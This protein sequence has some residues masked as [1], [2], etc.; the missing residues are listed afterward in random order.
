MEKRKNPVIQLTN[1]SGKY[2]LSVLLII[3]AAVSL[4]NLVQVNL[5]GRVVEQ[6]HDT[7]LQ[8]EELL[9][10]A[11]TGKSPISSLNSKFHDL[12]QKVRLVS[13]CLDQLPQSSELGSLDNSQ[14]RLDSVA[15][16]WRD[17]SPKDRALML[18][19]ILPKTRRDIE[20]AL[21]DTLK[22]LL[23]FKLYLLRSALSTA[24]M[25]IVIPVSW[26]LSGSR[27][28]QLTPR[29]LA[30]MSLEHVPLPAA[31]FDSELNI[32]Y[33][34]SALARTT[35]STTSDFESKELAHLINDSVSDR[36]K[37]QI[38]AST[39]STEKLFDGNIS[40]S[41]RFGSGV[42][43]MTMHQVPITDEILVFADFVNTSAEIE[44]ANLKR[45]VLAIAG[46]E[47]RT[48]LTS[49]PA[50]ISLAL[51]DEDNKLTDSELTELS[52]ADSNL[53]VLCSLTSN[54]ME[55]AASELS[56][57]TLTL[58]AITL[59]KLVKQ[60]LDESREMIAKRNLTISSN[61]PD[62][63]LF[64]D[65]QKV[66]QALSAI[67]SYAI[68][69]AQ[70]GTVVSISA[71]ITDGASHLSILTKV[72]SM[73]FRDSQ[74]EQIKLLFPALVLQSHGGFLEVNPALEG[75]KKLF[76]MKLPSKQLPKNFD[77]E[78]SHV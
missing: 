74:E 61:L 12:H 31:A 65:K 27:L 52:T 53:Q 2:T 44:A 73:R 41:Q 47:L 26:Q 13:Q 49:I 69:E 48:P 29:E 54:L 59:S 25:L 28:R 17:A 72:D 38:A 24:L 55:M 68:A 75:G 32:I 7:R 60:S 19:E 45:D 35:G 9:R 10:A 33:V 51:S 4:H 66:F 30:K 76:R 23:N 20:F 71:S 11:H 6:L 8:C 50:L 56:L 14:V 21:R 42:F 36:I 46:H 58:S 67:L 63:V 64:V 57:L 70:V 62:S 3:L 18:E 78:A 40:F 37:S 43:R 5:H 16:I 34:N 39:K 22:Q 15:T 77:K 1:L